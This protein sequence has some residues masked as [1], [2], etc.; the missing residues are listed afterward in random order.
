MVSVNQPL[1]EVMRNFAELMRRLLELQSHEGQRSP[2]L[3]AEDRRLINDLRTRS[4]ERKPPQAVRLSHRL[5][6]RLKA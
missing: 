4:L 1:E 6:E 2:E 5:R 3:I